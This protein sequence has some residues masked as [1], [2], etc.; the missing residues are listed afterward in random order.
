MNSKIVKRNYF[1][2]SVY[3]DDTNKDGF[4]NLKDLR[5]FYLFDNNGEKQKQ[6]IPANYSVFK[7]E[8][9]SDNDFMF[10]FARLDKNNNGQ[11]DDN[12]PIN[13]FWVDLKDPTKTG[14]QY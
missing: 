1:L 4:I 12:E 3:N 7:S 14:Q 5:R 13:I 8:Y 2:V 11:I 10:V 9:D 6:L